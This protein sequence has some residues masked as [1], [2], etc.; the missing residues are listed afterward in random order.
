[1]SAKQLTSRLIKPYLS[2]GRA[3][4]PNIP[5]PG[6]YMIYQNNQIVYIGYSGTN[7]Y[8]TLY[9]H[10]QKWNDGQTRIVYNKNDE[11]IKI[12]VTYTNS[13]YR[14]YKL[15][16]ALI[17]KHAPRDNP[18]KYINYVLSKQ[19]KQRVEDLINEPKTDIQIFKGD[20]PF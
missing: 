13:A 14:A 3:N 6:V 10:F 9:R 17:V 18:N 11:S 1:M 20:L 7:I 15:E 4:L 16:R 19:D 12:R 5:R 8:K 2:N